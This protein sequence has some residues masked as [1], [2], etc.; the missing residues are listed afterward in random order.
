MRRL[1]SWCVPVLYLLNGTLDRTAP[2][3]QIGVTPD[4]FGLVQS[5]ASAFWRLL[6][7]KRRHVLCDQ[8]QISRWESWDRL[9]WGIGEGSQASIQPVSH[10]IKRTRIQIGSKVGYVVQELPNHKRI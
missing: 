4:I 6:T 5:V 10:S 7:G 8:I 3:A 9:R 1:Y 2:D